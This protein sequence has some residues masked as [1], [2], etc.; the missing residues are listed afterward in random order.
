MIFYGA[1]GHAKVVIEAWVESGGKVAAI[2][3]DNE[4]IQRLLDFPVEQYDASKWAKHPMVISIGHNATRKRLAA[5]I[6]QKYGNV[7]HKH[8]LI[9]K[10]ATI[11]EGTVIMAGAIINA[12]AKIGSHVIINTS[13]V[14]EHDCS[15]GDYAHISPNATLCGGVTVGEGAQ[16]SA[17]ATVIPGIAIGKW[18]VV[19]AGSVIIQNVPD[20][21]VVVG[22]PGKVVGS[23]KKSHS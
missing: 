18:A 19:G 15:V 22:V 8:S 13:A 20:F 2:V 14:V 6:Q 17:G 21:S 16:V 12:E 4:K 23:A 11:G 7:I 5:T 10:S 3:D 1:S 9:A